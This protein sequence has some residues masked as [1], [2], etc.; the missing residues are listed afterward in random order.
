MRKFGVAPK[1]MPT[2][3]FHDRTGQLEPHALWKRTVQLYN[4]RNQIAHATLLSERI[5][6]P[7]RYMISFVF[8]RRWRGSERPRRVRG[9]TDTVFAA[10]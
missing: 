4:V 7:A 5:D 9:V 10:T 8:G 3:E 1:P 6:V 2:L